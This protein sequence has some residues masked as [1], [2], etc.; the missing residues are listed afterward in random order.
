MCLDEVSL[1]I[2]LEG[3]T[4]RGIQMFAKVRPD[5]K[6]LLSIKTANDI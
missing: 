6:C 5:G 1:V 2:R 4:T 3:R